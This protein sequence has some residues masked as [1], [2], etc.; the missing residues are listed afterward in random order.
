MTN[1]P[2]NTRVRR[3]EHETTDEQTESEQSDVACPECSGNLIVDDEHGETVCEDCGL[4]VEGLGRPRPRV[5]RVRRRR[6]NEK[7]RVGAPTTNTMHDKGL[8]TNIDW[9]NKDAYGNSSV[10]PAR[11]DAAPAQVERALPDA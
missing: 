2:S 9:R 4:V 11:E 10:A 3:S 8:S 5:A 1:A 7:S 6:E